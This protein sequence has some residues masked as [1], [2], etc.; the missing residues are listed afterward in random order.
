MAHR[1]RSVC[2]QR[3][4]R[5]APICG[6]DALEPRLLLSTAPLAN[7]GAARSMAVLQSITLSAEHSHDGDGS[8]VSYA[9]DLDGD[10]QFDDATGVTAEFHAPRAG[11]F[12][13]AV[14]VTDNDGRTGTDTTD[15]VAYD[16]STGRR[17]E[18]YTLF[19]AQ[20]TTT[21]YLMDNDGNIVHTW[22]V[23]YP[24]GA[25]ISLLEN[26]QLLYAG[27]INSTTFNVGG[28]GGIV[29]MIAWDGT[30]TWEF[31]YAGTEYLQHHDVTGLPNGNVL[32][33]T[34][35]RK[36]N[37]EAI[38]AGRNPA[39]LPDGELWPDSIIEI[40]PV[41]TSGGNIVWE[42][43]AWDHVVQDFDATKA[44][45]GV[46]ADHPELIDLNYNLTPAADWHHMNA[47]TYNAELDQIL[48]STRQFS[49][50]WVIDHSTTTQEA[51]GH[52]GGN[53]GRGG[54]LLY[55]WG[56]PATY[57]AGSAADQTLFVQH[58]AHWIADGLP[59][60]GHFLVFNNGVGRPGG[61][62][63]TVDEF[64]APLNPD[65]SYA[66]TRGTAFGPDS[67]TWTY[68]AD[69]PSDF[70]AFFMS[71]AQR[72][73]NGNTLVINGMDSYFFEVTSSGE[74]VWE[75]QATGRT[76]RVQRYAPEFSGFDGT[77]LD[78]VPHLTGPVSSVAQ[79]SPEITWTP[80]RNATSYNVWIKNL[81]T[82]VNPF[83]RGTSSTTSYV[84]PSDLGIG[85]FRVWVQ[86][87]FETVPGPWSAQATFSINTPVELNPI[88][89]S[90]TNP[91]PAFSWKVLPGAV[92]YDLWV[93]NVSDGTQQFV[94]KP[95]LSSSSWTAPDDW[96]IG[97]YRIWVR[98][99]D[100]SGTGARWSTMQETSV[101]TPP[102][103][104]APL[105]STF[106]RTPDFSWNPV[107]G[108]A[109]Y[110]LFVRN[111]N[112]GALVIHESKIAATSWSPITPVPDGAFQW[113][114]VGR[115]AQNF[116]TQSSQVIDF[117][118]GGRP[119][120]IAP[121]GRIPNTQPTFA[122]KPVEGAVRYELF[123][124]R[125]GVQYH[126]L[127][128]TDI[129]TASYTPQ[130]AIPQGTYRFWIRAFSST[131]EISFWSLPM[132]FTII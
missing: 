88:P 131:S 70:L 79:Q 106:D 116:R 16:T 19:A 111:R 62:Y 41:G 3:R 121:T 17:F 25:A 56:N 50:V 4:R 65:G 102:V 72:L 103:A 80:V 73:P 78:D 5:R 124:D 114:V 69:T 115:S 67:T 128:K 104:A 94:R 96:P 32:M 29:Q 30:V 68:A 27:N 22:N 112:T 28:K 120:L 105:S 77:P 95:N 51:A 82:N 84:P 46:V 55:R 11:Q 44:N 1:W 33:V 74:K 109:D 66:L 126:F 20:D 59:G 37:A 39:L 91:R 110:E 45:F 85:R 118:V 36:T 40:E 48:M 10:G 98:A 75:Y 12:R 127:N 43:H 93:D 99:K 132:T 83:H 113:W 100:K 24:P 6:A 47:V 125:I 31:R 61:D 60:E 18:G 23:Q 101:V 86:P 34:W 38:A 58:N 9:W 49:E 63:S 87:V 13:V 64:V 42:W 97:K 54:D 92:T 57:R 89:E 26:G 123:V 53:S 2:R 15:I 52:T 130:I 117:Y 107:P 119:D 122:W 8:I 76:F 81:S 14:K 71:G 7:A 21:V 129:T 90:L 108:A 35:Q